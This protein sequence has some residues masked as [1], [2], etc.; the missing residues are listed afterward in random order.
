MLVK[1]SHKSLASVSWAD[2]GRRIGRALGA[3]RRGRKLGISGGRWALGER[4]RCR[5]RGDA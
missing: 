3:G 1:L 4:G 5:A 2:V